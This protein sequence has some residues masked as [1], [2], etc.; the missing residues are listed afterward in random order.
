MT[1]YTLTLVNRSASSGNFLVFQQ[2]PSMA[3]ALS[4]AWLAR[5]VAPG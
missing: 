3:N 2:P 4:A 5:P 1:Q